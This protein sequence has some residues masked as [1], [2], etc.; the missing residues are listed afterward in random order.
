M[1]RLEQEKLVA[2][3]CS[4]RP[5]DIGIKEAAEGGRK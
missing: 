1:H 5:T 3:A 4:E 2:E